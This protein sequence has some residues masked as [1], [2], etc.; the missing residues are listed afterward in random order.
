MTHRIREA[1][2]DDTPIGMGSGG[3]AVEVDET[4][5]GRNENKKDRH[6][7]TG[8]GPKYM[9]SVLSLVDRDTGAPAASSSRI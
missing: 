2:R 7:K 8:R 3:G 9:N 4:F 5:I 1:M 6:R